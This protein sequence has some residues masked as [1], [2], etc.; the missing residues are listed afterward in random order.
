VKAK[1][2]APLAL[3]LVVL[4]TAGT[5]G[6]RGRD[7]WAA[8]H[9]PLRLDP[10]PVGAPCPASHSHP[11]DRGHLAGLGAGPIYPLTSPFDPYDRQPGW[12]GSKT[13]WTWPASLRTRPAYVLVRGRRLDQP[14][15][16][17]FQLG[18]QWDTAPLT[19]ELRID[20]SR[21]VG[22]FGD[23]TWGTTV[24]M[25]LART[26]GCYGLQLDSRRG[27]NVIVLD[28]TAP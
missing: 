7:P 28:G 17:R 24:T 16:M 14:G 1:L 21:T 22:S 4:G 9:R 10:L 2:L 12:L 8:L 25:L 5:T 11:L 6:A 15:A 23:S 26:P 19:A 13:I 18:P 3:A 20:T 27:T